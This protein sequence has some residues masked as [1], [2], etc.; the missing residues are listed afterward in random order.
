MSSTRSP[1]LTPASS[2][3]RSLT[4]CVCLSSSSCQARHPVEAVSQSFRCRSRNSAGSICIADIGPR[5]SVVGAQRSSVLVT[6]ASRCDDRGEMIRPRGRTRRVGAMLP[7][8]AGAALL[9]LA[10][11]ARAGAPQPLA[12]KG[13][14][15]RVDV[16]YDFDSVDPALADSPEARSVE[17]LTCTTLFNV[18]GTRLVPDAA[19]SSPVVSGDGLTYTVRLRS[20]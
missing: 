10:V 17:H 1:P 2:I 20:G 11:A 13:G 15:L 12:A 3:N 14:T 5:V 19:A 9:A 16:R 6:S 7:F 8:I 18:S 4:G